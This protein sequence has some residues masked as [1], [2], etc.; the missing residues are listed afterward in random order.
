MM[1]SVHENLHAVVPT[2]TGF[3]FSIAYKASDLDSKYSSKKILLT[4]LATSLACFP[5]DGTLLIH[6][7]RG[8]LS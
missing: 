3:A 1:D 6:F 7:L 5:R 4:F 8:H 2:V